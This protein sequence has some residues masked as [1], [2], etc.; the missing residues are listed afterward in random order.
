ML[1]GLLYIN[2]SGEL[3]TTPSGPDPKFWEDAVKQ[4]ELLYKL[5][6]MWRKEVGNKVKRK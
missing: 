3:T 4:M 2:Q 5:S 1:T 6:G